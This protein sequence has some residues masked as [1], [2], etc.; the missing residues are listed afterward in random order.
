MNKPSPVAQVEKPNLKHQIRL[1]LALVLVMLVLFGFGSYVLATVPPTPNSWY[2]KCTL[3]ESTGLHC[4]G[5]GTTRATHAALQGHFLA[6]L[7]Y[8]IL[9]VIFVPVVLFA[10]GR[11]AVR[12]VLDKPYFARTGLS[13][14]WTYAILI[15]VVLFG[16]ARNIPVPPFTELAPQ[17]LTPDT[18]VNRE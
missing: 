4:P 8:N 9:A 18:Q 14:R 1:R 13:N 3:H 15:A 11:H 17:E 6:A 5:C 16:I 10:V 2:P 7:R 12:W